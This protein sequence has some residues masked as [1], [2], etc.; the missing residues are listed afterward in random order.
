MNLMMN[1]KYLE[2]RFQHVVHGAE[3][4][5]NRLL[6]R[7]FITVDLGS[8]SIEISSVCNLKC[9]FCPYEKKVTPKVVMSNE[10]FFDCVNQAVDLG[11]DRFELTPC[12]GDVFM[13]RHIFEKLDFLD[14]HPKVSQYS[15][16]SNLT[17]PSHDQ[18][19]QLTKLK[20]L[21]GLTVS[22]YGHD[23][24]SFIDITKSTSKVYERLISNLKML[25]AQKSIPFALAFGWR[26]TGD[27]P[28]KD[29]SEIMELL[30]TF[31][32]AG[33]R[34]NSPHGVFNNWGGLISQDDVAGL[35]MKIMPGNK[36]YKSGACVKLFDSIQITASGIVNACACRDVNST[37]R[38][39]DIRVMPLKK[40]ISAENEDYMR[41]IEEQQSGKFRP[42]CDGCDFFRSVYHQPSNY[43]RGKIP[44][45]TIPE[46]ISKLR[47]DRN[48][49]L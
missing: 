47:N 6:G 23:E 9:K 40:I 11:Y 21:V 10:M 16:F 27:V 4:I 34:F 42:V 29:S 17:I 26:S 36:K 38:I 20:K 33:A 24:K 12:T 39:G 43:R 19:M 32:K 18:L 14:H 28:N 31:K 22:I 49:D 15:F 41:L 44:T 30:G 37:L 2:R 5:V 8:M 13:D 7:E 25:L 1:L 3:I 35:N 45:Q 48:R 46:F